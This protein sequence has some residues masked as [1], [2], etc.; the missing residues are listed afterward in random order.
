MKRTGQEEC[1]R[2]LNLLLIY[3]HKSENMF[4]CQ[5]EQVTPGFQD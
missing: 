2:F 1:G 3:G 4:L 5:R